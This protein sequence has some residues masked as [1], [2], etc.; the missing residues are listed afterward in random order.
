M[1]GSTRSAEKMRLVATSCGGEKGRRAD[2]PPGS[3]RPGFPHGAAAHL[4]PHVLLELLLGGVHRPQVVQLRGHLSTAKPGCLPPP[5][6]GPTDPAPQTLRGGPHSTSSAEENPGPVL[7]IQPERFCGDI[8]E[9]VRGS[10]GPRGPGVGV[11]VGWGAHLDFL[12]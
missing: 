3:P 11:R 9:G 4:L 1:S 10:A 8:R 6:P 5:I 7:P 12:S 2:R